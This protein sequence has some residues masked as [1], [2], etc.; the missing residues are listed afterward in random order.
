MRIIA[1]STCDLDQELA[2]R[3][4]IEIVP[5]TVILKDRQYKDR[6]EI[7][8]Q[9]LFDYV[10]VFNELPKTSPVSVAGFVEAFQGN[11]EIVYISISSKLSECYQNAIQAVK[12]LGAEKRIHVIDSLSLTTGTGLLVLRAAELRNLGMSA[13]EIEEKIKALV[14]KVRI[15]ILLDTLEYVR[16]G[17]RCSAVTAIV[18]NVLNIHPIL[19]AH[20]DGTLGV[21]EK[22]G[23]SRSKALQA[24][25]NIYERDLENIDL[26]R[27]SITH[28][29]CPQD[30][31]W[32]KGELRN[33]S[34]PAEILINTAG[35]VVS[36]HTGPNGIA[37]MYIL[38]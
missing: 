17:G 6:L 21:K 38:K 36:S 10:K 13:A 30:A 27:V 34:Q 11:D 19:E 29:G 22:I 2:K 18:S 32:M 15:A 23:G 35:G 9:Q 12:E 4:D 31:F 20:P 33:T 7:E 16:K 3:Y 26:R 37:I 1:D 8:T 5:L 25:I 14:P 24:L 28:T